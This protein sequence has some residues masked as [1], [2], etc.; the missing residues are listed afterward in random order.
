[1]PRGVLSHIK[2]FDGF[3]TISTFENTD[4]GV[5][6]AVEIGESVS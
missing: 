4:L 3:D 5:R 6:H 2:D 1:M